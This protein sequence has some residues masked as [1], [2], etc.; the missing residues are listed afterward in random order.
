MLANF[1][2]I[3]TIDIHFTDI[4]NLSSGDAHSDISYVG[5]SI[6]DGKRIHSMPS[7]RNYVNGE[8]MGPNNEEVV[9][10]FEHEDLIG[11][12]GATRTE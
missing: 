11:A 12:F 3:P 4:V 10:V 6:S 1:G 8:F 2:E 5:A 9:G 7:A